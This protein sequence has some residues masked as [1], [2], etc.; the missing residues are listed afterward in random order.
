MRR[1]WRESDWGRARKQRR[2]A[3][4]GPKW[5]GN[6][7]D[8]GVFLGVDIL[9]ENLASVAPAQASTSRGS[10]RPSIIETPASPS[11]GADTFV[12]AQSHLS[13]PAREQPGPTTLS[14]NVSQD[15]DSVWP[16]SASSST[17]LLAPS[18]SH[19]GP[20]VEQQHTNGA[21]TSAGPANGDVPLPRP[22]N[23]GRKSTGKGMHVHY[24]E[25]PAVPPSEVLARRGSAVDDTS[26]GAAEQATAEN[27]V[28]WGDVIMRDRMLVRVSYTEDAVPPHFDETQ[29]RTTRHLENEGW[30]EYI[31]AWRKDRLEL[32]AD[33]HTPGKEWLTGHKRLAFV[34]PLGSSTTRLSLYSFVDLTFCLTC[35]PSRLRLDGKRRRHIFGTSRGTNI[36]IF[37]LK[38]RSRAVDWM[39]QLWRHLG[40]D[41]PPY[42]DIRSPTLDTRI[43]IDVPEFDNANLEAAYNIFNRDNILRLCEKYLRTVPEFRA[44]MKREHD[45]GATFELAWRHEANLDWVW[46]LSD[47]L[48]KPRKWSVL[49]GLALT[50]GGRPA[51][52]EF[53]RKRHVPTRLR[54]RDGTRLDEPLAVEGFL[55][56]IRPNSQLKQSIYLVTHDG[57]LFTLAPARAQPPPAPG[58]PQSAPTS[59]DAPDGADTRR[60]EEV[61]R[62][63]LQILEA[64]GVSDL[65]SIVAVRRAFQVVARQTEPVNLEDV[66]DWEDAQEFWAEVERS[67]SDDED[68]GG[69]TGLAGVRDKGRLRMRRSFELVLASGRVLRFEAYSC[70]TALE[71]ITRLRPLISYWKKR[72]QYD[73]R[74]EM[75]IAHGSTGRPRITPQRMKED[76][77]HGHGHEADEEPP[78]DRDASLP[79]LD[80]FYNW[81][82][83]DGCR[84]ILKGGRLYG[85]KGWWGQYKHIQ[86]VLI[87]GHLV[88]YHISGRPSL[89]HRKD[90]VIP[91]LDAYLCSGYFAAQYLPEGQY[92]ANAPP[93]ARRYQDGLETDDGEEDTLF[94]IWYRVPKGAAPGVR[95][96]NAGADVPPLTAKRKVAVFRTR[97]KLERD[98]WVWAVNAEIEKV[99][100]A[101]R[102]REE[103]V[104]NA[105][106]LLRT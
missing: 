2:Q 51:H 92:D 98:A 40:G 67:G 30:V 18:A 52:L 80:F 104:R 58:A 105:G 59:S 25:T 42:I 53:R 62:G 68:A 20:L 21:S 22:A 43:K 63:Q 4:T 89:H 57:Y 10:V 88:Q 95:R 79:D 54:L 55:D 46:R 8:V 82:V 78:P 90:K 93:V 86:L 74:I 87:S 85:R 97:S 69:D 81:C 37:K 103:A 71:W 73:A 32:Y 75:D 56:R 39:W 38:S 99:V 29:N 36:F 34:V 6:S 101:S 48:Q 83:L 24:E 31:V 65:R 76:H 70:A 49:C 19:H 91:L 77:E 13:T 26:A 100:R 33:H 14:L 11:A 72:H 28:K 9:D 7:F 15:R 94:V 3:G 102:V 60:K 35:P 45:E 50:Q 47:V 84:P 17:A 1:R 16:G 44:L 23:Q 106:E 61:R 5:V 96:N 12:T 41:L 64:T 66:G 27:Q